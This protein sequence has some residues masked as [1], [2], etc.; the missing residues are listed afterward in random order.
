VSTFSARK[1]SRCAPSATAAIEAS[2]PRSAGV[3]ER[4]YSRAASRQAR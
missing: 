1:D 2:A 4:M 3:A